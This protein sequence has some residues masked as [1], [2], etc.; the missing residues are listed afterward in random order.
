MGDSASRKGYFYL[1]KDVI[2]IDGS[3]NATPPT[4]V[5]SKSRAGD[6]ADRLADSVRNEQRIS[7]STK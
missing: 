3:E 2:E 5:V 1:A 6:R 7:I 4:E